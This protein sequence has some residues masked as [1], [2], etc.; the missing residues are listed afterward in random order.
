[1]EA[2]I[3]NERQGSLE[4]MLLGAILADPKLLPKVK[5]FTD[6]EIQELS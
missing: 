4:L 5:G 1:M 6:K 3:M 2:Q